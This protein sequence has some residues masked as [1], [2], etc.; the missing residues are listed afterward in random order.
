L[1]KL[2]TTA[3]NLRKRLTD[4][5]QLL[6]SQLRTRQIEGCKFR[7]QTPIGK[8]IVDFICH[9]HRLIVEVDGGQHSENVNEDKIRDT[10]LGE[11]GYKI[12]RFW[13][14]EV[15]TNMEGV[16]EVIRDN[17]KSHPPLHPLPSREGEIKILN[18]KDQ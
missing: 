14:N 10:W 13:N 18:W 4:T 5:E 12:L 16:L 9:E 2:I 1:F 6:W 3:R 17:C 11:Q 7:R 15:L 8:Y